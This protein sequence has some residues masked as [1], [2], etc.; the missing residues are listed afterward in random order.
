MLSKIRFFLQPGMPM[1]FYKAHKGDRRDV[2]D[3]LWVWRSC[4]TSSLQIQTLLIAVFLPMPVE[5]EQQTL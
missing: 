5:S 1:S 4:V 2:T 3:G